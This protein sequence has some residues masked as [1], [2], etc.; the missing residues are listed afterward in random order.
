MRSC[1]LKIL[2]CILCLSAW[3]SAH[4]W[5]TRVRGGLSDSD[6][7]SIYE[8]LPE[9]NTETNNGPI[10]LHGNEHAEISA[11]ALQAI[12]AGRLLQTDDLPVV[13]DLNASYFRRELLFG[14]NP[15]QPANV[16]KDG[17]ERRILPPPAQFSGLP[18]FSYTLYDWINKNQLCPLPADA[19]ERDKCHNY[20]GWIGA[21]L[22]ASHFG[23]QAA[24]NYQQL[25]QI[26]L[27]LAERARSL[28]VKLEQIPEAP[29]AYRKHLV[30]AEW[31]ALAY[32]GM[33]QHFLADRWSTGHMWER[34]NAGDYRHLPSSDLLVNKMTGYI[35]GMF[36]GMQT[37]LHARLAGRSAAHHL[38]PDP[39]SSPMVEIQHQDGEVERLWNYYVAGESGNIRLLSVDP[40]VYR[41]AGGGPGNP[42]IGDY[43]FRDLLD[44]DFGG[45]EYGFD[46]ELPLPLPAQREEMMACIKG[47][48]ADVIRALGKNPSGGYG[49]LSI[50]LRRDA[51]S[52]AALGKPCFDTYVTNRS[53]ML[54]W[55]FSRPSF[56]SQLGRAT[57]TVLSSDT[58]VA[59]LEK[60]GKGHPLTAR[61]AQTLQQALQKQMA[62]GRQAARNM[63]RLSY[64]AWRLGRKHPGG[65]GLARGGLGALDF[66]DQATGNK[67]DAFVAGG[68]RIE[69]GDQYPAADYFPKGDLSGLPEQNDAA[70]RDKEAIYGFFSRAMADH[71][72]RRLA[73][74]LPTL[75]GS[76]TPWKQALCEYL[77]DLAYNGTNP[78]YQGS[79]QE[80]RTSN[81]QHDGR[82]IPS[83]LSALGVNLDTDSVPVHLPPGYVAEPYARTRNG[84]GYR[85][86]Q[87][88][89]ARMPVLYLLKAPEYRDR[90]VVA[91]T[92]G[93]GMDVVLRGADLG[94]E[95]R[96]VWTG[97]EFGERRYALE[98]RSWSRSSV[99]VRIPAEMAEGRHS[100]C[101]QRADGTG[102]IGRYVL[103]FRPGPPQVTRVVIQ[104]RGETWYRQPGGADRPLGGGSYTLMVEFDQAMDLEWPARVAIHGPGGLSLH[105]GEWIS[106]RRWQARLEIPD[107]ST[108]PSAAQ[109]AHPLE[110]SARS[111]TGFILDTDPE[112]PGDQPERRYRFRVGGGT[113]TAGFVG[114]FRNAADDTAALEIGKDGH[115]LAMLDGG[116]VRFPL[117][118]SMSPE[119]ELVLRLDFSPET[120]QAY[121]RHYDGAATGLVEQSIPGIPAFATTW[122]ARCTFHLN[123]PT[124]SCPDE[125]DSN[126][127]QHYRINIQRSY[128]EWRLILDMQAASD[129]MKRPLRVTRFD[130]RLQTWD[131]GAYAVSGT[132]LNGWDEQRRSVMGNQALSMMQ[133][134]DRSGGRIQR[135]DELFA[136]FISDRPAR[137]QRIQVLDANGSPV[138]TT[139]ASNASFRIRAEGTS[140]CPGIRESLPVSVSLPGESRPMRIE[141]KET[142]AD[143]GIFEGPENPLLAALPQSTPRGHLR[144]VA[145][146][147][148]RSRL[149][150]GGIAFNGDPEYRKRSAGAS[151]SIE[152]RSGKA[153]PP[154]TTAWRSYSLEIKHTPGRS[155]PDIFVIETQYQSDGWTAHLM[156]DRYPVSL[157]RGSDN[158]VTLW[159]V[160]WLAPEHL[161][162][163]QANDPAA[164]TRLVNRATKL[165]QAGFVLS[166]LP[167][168]LDAVLAGTSRPLHPQWQPRHARQQDN[169]NPSDKN[170]TYQGPPYQAIRIAKHIPKQFDELRRSRVYAMPGRTRTETRRPRGSVRGIGK[171]VTIVRE[172]L[173]LVWDLFEETRTYMEKPY[174]PGKLVY[175]FEAEERINGKSLRRY[176][177]RSQSGDINIEGKVWKDE[178]GIPVR[179]VQ[180]TLIPGAGIRDEEFVL[181]NVRIGPLDAS[182]FELPRDYQPAS[183]L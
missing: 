155:L 131:G 44:G 125:N 63:V 162:E 159:R 139:L 127:E 36:H 85:S 77:A 119:H 84:Q 163:T 130:S 133:G 42:G 4:A 91:T 76:R 9:T 93:A 37:V 39:L 94:A 72:G 8:Q 24:R 113:V 21:A 177:F 46:N 128:I 101:L 167:E 100:L 78:A 112:K 90:N 146:T 120:F 171:L 165:R 81:G 176:R 149:G 145:D 38:W 31:M 32:E 61:A 79:Q 64:R 52:L 66:S 74:I 7:R 41:H 49:T 86:L 116:K 170:Y 58:G 29:Q 89:C 68:K 140:H 102:T 95:R 108:G 80:I 115:A 166:R 136:G 70:G 160:S 157:A 132:D 73:E 150:W 3:P 34:W 124:I 20:N 51:P 107:S 117:L 14:K 183:G 59:A 83:Y 33:A 161:E 158:N 1:W 143:T 109:G 153:P 141:L 26:A 50:P 96:Q 55:P 2:A 154:P 178:H 175:T 104:G 17:L 12:G 87:A 25:H 142:G 180:R 10:I 92:R 27:L 148:L 122:V 152:V 62:T 97:C 174:S 126:Q 40:A 54:A 60:L 82:A 129:E 110:I 103:E 48:W 15:W 121:Y 169:A 23:T 88:W 47:G 5:D 98:I 45:R 134:T 22:N 164:F 18:D 179:Q 57:L 114:C 111:L 30:E 16:P 43:G 123:G 135:L 6:W 53:M 28:R 11:T 181:E 35:S 173:G 151:L 106:E 65:M 56:W 144:V 67:P 147:E 71:W 138:S 13:T 137:V 182:L 168:R 105:S 118:A 172:D 69:P 156:R 99:T 19:P 75:R